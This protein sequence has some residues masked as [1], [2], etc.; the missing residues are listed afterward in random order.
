MA[1]HPQPELKSVAVV[2]FFEGLTEE[3]G[4]RFNFSAS[5][6]KSVHAVGGVEHK[7]NARGDVLALSL[8]L[9]AQRHGHKRHQGHG[10][11][12]PTKERMAKDEIQH[13]WL[14]WRRFNSPPTS[15]QVDSVRLAAVHRSVRCRATCGFLP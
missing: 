7:Q 8:H 9:R 4:R 13:G 2:Q 10:I 1:I 5:T 11:S 3:V 12:N 14:S 15:T 6:P